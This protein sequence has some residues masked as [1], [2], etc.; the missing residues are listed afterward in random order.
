M[1]DPGHG[2]QRGAIDVIETEGGA[3]GKT[4]KPSF[5]LKYQT[6]KERKMVKI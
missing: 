5:V 1:G 3:E 4:W 6:P 2:G